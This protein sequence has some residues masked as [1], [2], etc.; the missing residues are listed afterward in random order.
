MNI[1]TMV[2]YA[3]VVLSKV[4]FKKII[5]KDI[6]SFSFPC[7][8]LFLFLWSKII[9]VITD[10]NPNTDEC[11]DSKNNI[12]PEIIEKHTSKFYQQQVGTIIRS[13][14]Y[15]FPW[16]STLAF[17]HLYPVQSFVLWTGA[18]KRMNT[19]ERGMYTF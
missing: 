12:W 17:T 15:S 9:F 6:L 3:S 2:K 11:W 19:K 4:P 1:W 8:F 18:Y 5:Y 10:I 13:L 16:S 14:Q 7:H